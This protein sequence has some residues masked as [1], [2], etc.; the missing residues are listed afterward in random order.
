M[1]ELTSMQVCDD[2][3]SFGDADQILDDISLFTQFF[4]G[5]DFPTLQGTKVA[6]ILKK[7]TKYQI[8]KTLRQLIHDENKDD[9]TVSKIWNKNYFSCWNLPHCIIQIEA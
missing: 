5:V 2:A 1:I 6:E 9:K 7:I 3:A 4:K 8:C